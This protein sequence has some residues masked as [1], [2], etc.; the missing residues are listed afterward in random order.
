MINL[1]ISKEEILSIIQKVKENI[2]ISSF[3]NLRGRHPNIQFDCLLRGYIGEYVF[4]KF[5]TSNGITIDGSNCYSVYDGMDVDFL[6][7]GNNVELK[8]SLVPDIDTDVKNVTSRDIKILK[9]SAFVE[10]LKGDIHV[11]LYINQRRK[12]KDDWLI[13]LQVDLDGDSLYLYNKL[14]CKEFCLRMLYYGKAS[15]LEA[16]EKQYQGVFKKL[17]KTNP[18]VF[19][20]IFSKSKVS[21][22]FFENL[23]IK[24]MYCDACASK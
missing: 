18:E 4:G 22:K 13:A 15:K 24:K 20:E 7:K 6:V 11:Q 3:D 9:R 2:R 5:L 8:V 12:A 1:P 10:D 16:F 19:C 23:H 17:Q 14:L 21:F